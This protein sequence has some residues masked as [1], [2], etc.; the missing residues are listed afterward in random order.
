MQIHKKCDFILTYNCLYL[1]LPRLFPNLK[2]EFESLANGKHSPK[3]RQ[4]KP[5]Y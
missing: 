3:I 2:N 1:L 5:K 4:N